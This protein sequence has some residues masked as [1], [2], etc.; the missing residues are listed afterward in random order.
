MS[1]TAHGGQTGLHNMQICT[2]AAEISTD[3]AP[4][5]VLGWRR[6]GQQQCFE[7]HDLAG[8]AETTLQ[9]VRVDERLLERIKPSARRES[10]DSRHAQAVAIDGQRQAGVHGD[11]VD[12][13]GACSA[14]AHV[15]DFFGACELQVVTQRVKK[16][17]TRLDQEMSS[18]TVDG[19]RQR[20]T[21]RG[22][23]HEPCAARRVPWRNRV[24]PWG[25]LVAV[26][27]RGTL[28]GNRGVLIDAQRRVV[29]EAQVRRWIT[30]VLSFKGRRRT[31]MTPEQYTE[32]FFL[33]EATALAAGHRPCAECRRAD[34]T[35]FQSLWRSVTGSL[36][37]RVDVMDR[38]LDAERRVRHPSARRVWLKKTWRADADALPDGTF[39][40][41]DHGAWMIRRGQ[42]LEWTS[43]GYAAR[44]DRPRGTVQVLTPPTIVGIL[45][46]GYPIAVHESAFFAS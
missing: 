1:A 15:A 32:L 20:M 27:D 30:C 17:V 23:G 9:C 39:I 38:E 18:D 21:A 45:R 5:V 46:A 14:V 41:I 4:D 34:F 35:R 28:M 24:T 33:D 6:V 31:V 12:E 10:L 29:R 16:R 26:P 43:S 13:D 3:R 25:T 37:A 22:R 36:D 8:C 11:V 42:A 19:Q 7:T 40:A 2:A 44:R